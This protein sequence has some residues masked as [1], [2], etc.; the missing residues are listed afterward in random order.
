MAT[1]DVQFDPPRMLIGGEL[2]ESQSGRSFMT[3]NP[4]TGAEL[5]A[6]PQGS[7]ADVDLAVERAA[8]AVGPWNDLDGIERGKRLRQFADLLRDHAERFGAIDA[9]DS[10]NPVSHMTDDVDKAADYVEVMANYVLETKGETIPVSN[11]SLNYTVRQPYGVVARIVPFNHPILFAGSKVAAPLA[12]GNTVVLKPSEVT[13]LSALEMGRLIAESDI[14]PDGAVNVLSGFGPEVGEPLVGHEAVRKIGLTGSVPT[15][16]AVT[17][18]ASDKVADV[19]LELGGKNPLVAYPDADL[20]AVIDGAIEGMNLTWQGES[21]GSISRL[22]LYERHYEDGIE[23]LAEKLA[24]ISPG[25]PLDDET[26]MG[27]LTGEKQYQKSMEYIQMAKESDARHVS[28]G[29]HPPGDELADGYFIEP[30]VFADVTMDMRIAQEEIFGPILFVFEWSDENEVIEAAN[31]VSYGLT[32]SVFTDDLQTAH[33]TAHKLEAGYIWINETASHYLGTP[34]GGWKESGLDQE[35]AL[36][37]IKAYTRLKTV[38]VPN[39][40]TR[41]SD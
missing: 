35:E 19:S 24:T 12:A 25:D 7:P 8:D 20:E 15:G 14:F 23:L 30:T 40:S 32:G 11:G 16:K 41:L 18:Q 6:I 5:A 37:E 22:F 33:E 1:I 34:F 39:I 31:S 21:C 27:A 36:E 29:E 38:H 17:K 13:S 4:A 26:Q 10:G 28:G 3:T 2:R 9:A